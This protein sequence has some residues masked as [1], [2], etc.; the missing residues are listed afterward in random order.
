LSAVVGPMTYGAIT[1]MTGGNYRTALL[2]T[3][4]FFILGLLVTL[5]VNQERGVKQASLAVDAA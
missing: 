2:S 3:I 4:G 5:R 1:R